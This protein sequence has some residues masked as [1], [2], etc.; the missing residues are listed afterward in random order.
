MHG[1]HRTRNNNQQK[2]A[3][4]FKISCN[5][6]GT[7]HPGKA[8]QQNEPIEKNFPAPIIIGNS[9]TAPLPVKQY[10]LPTNYS[11]HIRRHKAPLVHKAPSFPKI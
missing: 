5:N 1:L 9:A 8:F 4:A 6:V 10:H 3:A 11:H 7:T 2:I